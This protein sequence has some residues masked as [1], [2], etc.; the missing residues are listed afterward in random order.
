[1]S[2]ANAKENDIRLWETYTQTK[3][4]FD[5]K[6]VMDVM[7]PL[8][9]SRVQKWKGPIPEDILHAKAYQL[10]A[11]A[12][13]TYDPSRGA[14]LSTHIVNSLGPLSRTVYTYQNTARL[15]ENIT[16]QIHSYQV[17]KDHLSNDL[18]REPTTAELHESLGWSVPELNRMESYLRRDLTESV[19]SVQGSFYSSHEDKELDAVSAIYFDLLPEEKQLFE[20]LTGF[21]GKPKL[22]TEQMLHT[23]GIT[24]A[25][26]SYK[27]TL[28]TKKIAAMTSRISHGH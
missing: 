11:K 26:L 12:L 28:L 20:M 3:D 14:A 27:K 18:G 15:P 17:A 6:K 19:G 9:H 23:L 25:Q 7:A 4:P 16:L 8:I 5:R 21:H 1:M 2:T 24:Q 22:T 13:D 10:A